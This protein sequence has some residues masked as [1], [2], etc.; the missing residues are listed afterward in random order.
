MLKDKGQVAPEMGNSRAIVKRHYTEIVGA[1]T[2][3][4][5]RT[6]GQRRKQA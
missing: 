3:A 1:Y 4:S 2:P 5:A 6:S